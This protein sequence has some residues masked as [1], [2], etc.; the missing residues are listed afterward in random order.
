MIKKNLF[1]EAYIDREKDKTIN[2]K[3]E[4]GEERISVVLV[5]VVELTIIQVH[6]VIRIILRGRPPST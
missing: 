5:V 1:K 3:F 4:H 6:S 2:I